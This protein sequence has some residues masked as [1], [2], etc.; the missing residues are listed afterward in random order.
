MTKNTFK[1]MIIAL[2]IWSVYMVNITAYEYQDLLS[3]ETMISAHV[4][5][6][7]DFEKIFE[8]SS[9]GKLWKDEQFQK[10]IGEK[11]F[12][13]LFGKPNKHKVNENNIPKKILETLTG[14][15]CVGISRDD[16]ALFS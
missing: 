2:F 7:S 8:A 13:D 10:F 6:K 4:T 11:D 9:L 5:N 1:T 12:L 14:E 15:I 3:E 16:K